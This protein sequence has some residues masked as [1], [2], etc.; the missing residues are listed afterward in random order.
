MTIEQLLAEYT[1][2]PTWD[3]MM[4][5]RSVRPHYNSLMETLAQL[6]VEKIRQKHQQAS[7]LFMSQ[8]ITF[9]V[10]SDD[11]GIERIFPFDIIPRI[12]TSAEWLHIE[13]GIKQRLKA[14]NLFLH[15]IYHQQNCI[16][17]GIIPAALIASCPHFLSKQKS[18]ISANK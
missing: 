15:D 5:D 9:T 3:E 7:E 8:G 2:P 4:A 13:L 18:W 6:D 11:A 12:I 10:Y 17:D 14:L 1:Y 16:K